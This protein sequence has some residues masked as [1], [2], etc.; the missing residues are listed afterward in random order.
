M[1]PCGYRDE[2]RQLGRLQARGGAPCLL[3]GPPAAASRPQGVVIAAEAP[4][5]LESA[6]GDPTH[7]RSPQ[8]RPQIAAV[9]A[10]KERL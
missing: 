7:I 4:G 2:D 10:P 3:A 1:Y 5:G 8:R 6:P 9:V